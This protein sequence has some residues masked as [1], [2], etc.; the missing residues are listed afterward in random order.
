MTQMKWLGINIGYKKN[1]SKI[2]FVAVLVVILGFG[3]PSFAHNNGKEKKRNNSDTTVAEKMPTK[4][5]FPATT[6]AANN[7]KLLNAPLQPQVVSFVQQYAAKQSN[8]Y[9]KMKVWGKS[10]FDLY[11][12]I[13]AQYNIPAQLKYLSV[14]E[15]SLNPRTISWAGAV[16]PWQLMND[17][18]R[19]FG[20]RMNGSYD[21]RMDFYKSTHA[22][23]KLIKELYAT[24]GDWL[25]VVA[26]YNG[27]VGRVK[28]CIRKANS[29][30]FWDLQY[31]LPEETRTHVKK[32]IATH[33]I[34]EGG[35]G[36]TTMTAAETEKQKALFVT[37]NS[38]PNLSDEELNN[39][40]VIE[41]SGRYLSVIV[42]NYLLM[43]IDQFNK[44]NPSFDKNL[45]EGKKYQ[46]RLS[47]ERAVVF[48]ARKSQILLESV[49]TLLNGDNTKL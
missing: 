37:N 3:Y 39:T 22:A 47:K 7:V 9:E 2:S 27:G 5:L 8:E 20:L 19:R 41:V 38:V 17:E 40:T 11:D 28:Q 45:A 34:F 24:F 25:L 33:Y 36:W 10:Y 29:K 26:A 23:A 49:R 30:N 31:F 1:I 21:E 6:T 32:Y 35:G 13:L 15:S 18:G 46:L 44:W 12:N 16:G 42:T 14:I 43:D 4:S 48:E